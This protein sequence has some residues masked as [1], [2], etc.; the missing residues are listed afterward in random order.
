MTNME[1]VIRQ[2]PCGDEWL[3]CEWEDDGLCPYGI[4]AILETL[5][6]IEAKL[7]EEEQD[8]DRG[9]EDSR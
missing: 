1:K 2:Y 7:E 8:G 3:T 5:D 9:D 4:C 6:E